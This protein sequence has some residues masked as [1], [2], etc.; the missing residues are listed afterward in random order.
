MGDFNDI[1]RGVFYNSNYQNSSKMVENYSISFLLNVQ[2]T[3]T[4]LIICELQKGFTK[5]P[6]SMM[7]LNGYKLSTRPY[8]EDFN[9]SFILKKGFYSM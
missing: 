2:Y 6:K 1:D 3:T 5:Y 4:P 7:D 9:V 8:I